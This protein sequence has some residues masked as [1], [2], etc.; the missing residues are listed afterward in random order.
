MGLIIVLHCFYDTAAIKS[1]SVM[2]D[3]SVTLY[4]DTDI[5]TYY[6]IQ[7]MFGNKGTWIAN[8]IK[9][10]KLFTAYNGDSETFRNRLKLKGETGSLTIINMTTEHTGEY[11]LNISSRRR[12]IHRRYTVNVKGE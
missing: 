1:V 7:W 12:S 6:L 8:T 11:H 3:D 2:E 4:T 5:Q 9:V 10:D